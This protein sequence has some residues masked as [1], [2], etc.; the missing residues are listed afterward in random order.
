M[1]HLIVFCMVV[2]AVIAAPYSTTSISTIGLEEIATET[3]KKATTEGYEETELFLKRQYNDFVKP[4]PTHG[5]VK[6]TTTS[7]PKQT[8]TEDYEETE[9]FLR[10]RLEGYVKTT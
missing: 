6:T 4:T 3:S 10:R 5:P 8:V 2:A 9:L 1:K 7:K